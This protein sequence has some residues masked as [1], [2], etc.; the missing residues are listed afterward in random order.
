ML[1]NIFER[2]KN[3]YHVLNYK[4]NI[5]RIEHNYTGVSKSAI[6]ALPIQDKKKLE[7][8]NNFFL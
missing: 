4:N 1:A 3:D 6:V 2:E 7:I 5:T 8:E